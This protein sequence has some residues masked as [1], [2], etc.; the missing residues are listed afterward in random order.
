MS[1]VKTALR[2]ATCLATIVTM[3]SQIV[4]AQEASNQDEG[5]RQ[6]AV[7]RM[8]ETVTVT[9]TK[10]KDP[11]NV[12]SIATA[13][14]AFN[15]DTLDT[16]KV[17]D[18][19]DVSYS[20]PNVTLTDIGTTKGSANFAIRGLGVNSSIISIDPTV[21]VV[22][23]GIPLGITS[24]VV[25]DMFD[26]G[27]IEI[28]RGPQGILQGRNTVGGVVAVN[29]SN[30][31]DTL[32]YDFKV[33]TESPIDS[34]R[35]G[36]N[37]YV[38]GTV[39][40]PLI[41]GKLN[42]KIAA[43]YNNDEGYFKN[44]AT[45]ENHGQGDAK[46]IRGALEYLASDTFSVLAKL[47]Y[48]EFTGD[49]PSAQNRSIFSRDSFDISIDNEGF[50]DNNATFGS[51]KLNWDVGFGDGQITNITGYRKYNAEADADI[52]ALPLPLFHATSMTEQDQF[53]NELRYNGT[54][55]DFTVTT[56]LFYMEQSLAPKK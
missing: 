52:D 32:S 39:S 1:K 24:G 45:G 21:G 25:F 37:S 10:Q 13:V 12:Q 6:S 33:S 19:E 20:S 30:P 55:G 27:S 23:D 3:G 35:G 15:S 9:A 46:I 47:E 18:F 29:T 41:E 16:L 43:Y 44:K 11:E 28:L 48:A 49:G 22:V 5:T 8:M 51:L 14:T 56:G 53:S 54:F 2:G 7:Q 36:M 40:G 31:T 4:N 38:Q 17:R 50:Y 34:G 26:L 42:G